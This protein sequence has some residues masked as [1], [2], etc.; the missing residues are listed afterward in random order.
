VNDIG[1]ITF[2]TK[3]QVFDTEGLVSPEIFK[4]MEGKD[5]YEKAKEMMRMIKENNINFIIIYPNWYPEFMEL[6]GSSLEQKH[7]ERLRK[8]TICGGIEMFVYKIHW[9][10]INL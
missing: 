10:K 5:N 2:I 6:F 8:N 9:D 4:R 3:K 1:A 7:S